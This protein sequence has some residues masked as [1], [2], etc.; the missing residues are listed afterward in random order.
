MSEISL[1]ALLPPAGGARGRI[2]H[3]HAA[4][5]AARARPAAAPAR[6]LRHDAARGR[7]RLRSPAASRASGLSARLISVPSGAD[8]R[9]AVLRGERVGVEPGAL[10]PGGGFAYWRAQLCSSPPIAPARDQT[11]APQSRRPAGHPA[12]RKRSPSRVPTA[13]PSRPR[14]NRCSPVSG[15][16]AQ[17]RRGADA[18]SLRPRCWRSLRRRA[19][20]VFAQI[21]DQRAG[22]RHG[23]AVAAEQLADHV[24]RPAEQDMHQIHRELPRC[25]GVAGPRASACIRSRSDTRRSRATPSHKRVGD[26]VTPQADQPVAASPAQRRGFPLRHCPTRFI[27]QPPI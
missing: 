14:T 10:E 24:L 17:L 7:L 6:R 2:G 5:A 20:I 1:A 3:G 22:M 21:L 16:M 26:R 11:R 9:D 8:V 12:G 25:G 19:R 23:R 15:G 4:A 27:A 18:P 13:P